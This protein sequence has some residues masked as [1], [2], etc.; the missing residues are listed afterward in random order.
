MKMNLTENLSGL[1]VAEQY[2]GRLS[3]RIQTTRMCTTRGDDWG[4]VYDPYNLV[5]NANY[6]EAEGFVGCFIKGLFPET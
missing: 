5:T 3:V 2:R 1:V 6:G 4:Q